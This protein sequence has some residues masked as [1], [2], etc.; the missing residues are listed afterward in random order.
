MEEFAF[1]N[2]TMY[3]SLNS[4]LICHLTTLP[5]QDTV[6]NSLK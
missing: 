5:S 4:D 6:N 1:H 3:H 2:R